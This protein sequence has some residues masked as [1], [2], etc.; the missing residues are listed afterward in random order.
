V[1]AL[2]I[3]GPIKETIVGLSPIRSLLTSCRG[4]TQYLVQAKDDTAA[5]VGSPNLDLSEP[6]LVH[7]LGLL[8]VGAVTHE[9]TTSC[10]EKEISWE[11]GLTT[12]VVVVLVEKITSLISVFVHIMKISFHSRSWRGCFVS[13]L[14][15]TVKP[16]V[17][18]SIIA[19]ILPHTNGAP[20]GRPGPRALWSKEV[21]SALIGQRTRSTPV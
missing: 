2:P 13:I 12:F 8:C 6:P 21:C 9:Y 1:S 3:K 4:H 5:V 7:I 14:V 11:G 18:L 16:I 15:V 10:D 17:P 19:R 20:R